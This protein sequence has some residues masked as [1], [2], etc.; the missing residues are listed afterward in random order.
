MRST[1]VLKRQRINTKVLGK[2]YVW[3]Y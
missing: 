1:K 2:S 3:W